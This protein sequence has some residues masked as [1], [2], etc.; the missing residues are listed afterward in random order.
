MLVSHR[1]KLKF[2]VVISIRSY[3]PL[4]IAHTS[5][6]V[7]SLVT[8]VFQAGN[9]NTDTPKHRL[10]TG[11]YRC[12]S[13]SSSIVFRHTLRHWRREPEEQSGQTHLLMGLNVHSNLLRLIR[14][15]GKWGEWVLTSFHLLDTLSPPDWQHCEG[16]CVRH[17]NVS[18]IV[19]A[20]SQDSVH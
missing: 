1:K 3:P 12:T 2:L 17:F 13:H 9:F 10:S 19:W 15:G 11:K 5:Y 18:F 16:S 14:D 8:T 6:V 7:H 4:C 20:K